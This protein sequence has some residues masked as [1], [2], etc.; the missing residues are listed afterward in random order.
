MSAGDQEQPLAE[1]LPAEAR[2]AIVTAQLAAVTQE[3]D[4]LR[5][6]VR[7][8]TARRLPEPEPP[9][10]EQAEAHAE[11]ARIAMEREEAQARAGGTTS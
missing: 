2:L 9:P 11:A 4:F 7:S 6:I 8:L 10:E 5:D 1:G 3:G